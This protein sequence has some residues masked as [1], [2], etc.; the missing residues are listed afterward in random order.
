MFMY[1]Y[2]VE[3]LCV[4]DFKTIYCIWLHVCCVLLLGFAG[5]PDQFGINLH[6]G[7][8]FEKNPKNYVDGQ[9]RYVDICE[10]DELS[11]IEILNM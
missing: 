7:G 6:F 4:Y 1:I 3:L 9:V 8:Y 2:A 10:V 5:N 11:I